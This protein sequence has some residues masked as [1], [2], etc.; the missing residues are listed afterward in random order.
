MNFASEW[1]EKLHDIWDEN[2]DSDKKLDRVKAR[3]AAM[4]SGAIDGAVIMYPI[5]LVSL[6]VASAK[7]K[8]LE[9]RK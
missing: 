5:M 2:W 6:F 3:A 9:E 8:K 1:Q 4:C 7:I